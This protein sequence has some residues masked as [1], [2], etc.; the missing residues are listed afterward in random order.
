MAKDPASE[1]SMHRGELEAA[2]AGVSG[3]R[4]GER[5][6][7]VQS[8]GKNAEGAAGD[9]AGSTERTIWG[10]AGGSG[11]MASGSSVMEM[12]KVAGHASTGVSGSG[13]GGSDGR[14]KEKGFDG[15]VSAERSRAGDESCRGTR[16]ESYST[17][18]GGGRVSDS[19]AGY[20]D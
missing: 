1:G 4:R 19:A 8:S 9:M 10:H 20:A 6:G 13:Q 2:G 14:S 3:D 15:G 11:G 7:C 18:K 16:R 12:E 5:G 17:G